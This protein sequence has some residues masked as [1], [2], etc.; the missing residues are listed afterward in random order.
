MISDDIKI[1]Y[2]RNDRATYFDKDP[3]LLVA[4]DICSIFCIKGSYYDKYFSSCYPSKEKFYTLEE[5]KQNHR[6]I[7]HTYNW[8]KNINHLY[9]NEINKICAFSMN[10]I[11]Y[12]LRVFGDKA[13]FRFP[14]K[15]NPLY[16]DTEDSKY[17]FYMIPIVI[18][19]DLKKKWLDGCY[20]GSNCFKKMTGFSCPKEVK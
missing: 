7:T 8:W 6:I 15:V 1:R 4:E 14:E 3:N 20:I 13:R 19:P 9:C 12:A 5:I 10:C 16:I 18:K 2:Y 17:C 11:K